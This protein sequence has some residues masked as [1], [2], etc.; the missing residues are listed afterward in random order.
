MFVYETAIGKTNSQLREEFIEA[1]GITQK[2]QAFT[3][4]HSIS[5]ANQSVSRRR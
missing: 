1:A 3:P 2:M 4:R 5:G